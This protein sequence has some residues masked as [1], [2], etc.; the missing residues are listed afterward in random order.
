[1]CS[2]L[3]IDDPYH[4]C[5]TVDTSTL[6]LLT[7][8]ATITEDEMDF[9]ISCSPTLSTNAK[10]GRISKS[11]L[12]KQRTMFRSVLRHPF[13]MHPIKN[14][15]TGIN[16]G[17]WSAGIHDATFDD[18]MHSVEAGMVAYITETVYDG[19]T[20]KEKDTVEE[21]TRPMLDNQRCSIVSTYPRWR[22]QPGFTRQTLM[23]SGERVGSVLALSLSLQDPKI[24]E[25][26]RQGHF[27]QIQ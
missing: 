27:R 19:L 9:K 22:L 10:K 21:M 20:K 8:Y 14:A 5:K 6:N 11:F 12:L 26:I 1:M 3:N 4:D 16:F 24:R 13:T 15:F 2:Y 25:T 7:T 18:F 23:T 17:S